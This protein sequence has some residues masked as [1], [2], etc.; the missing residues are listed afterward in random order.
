MRCL[1]VE[2]EPILAEMLIDTL[3]D[4][5]F[6][7]THLDRGDGVVD[8]VKSEDPTVVL[9]DLMLPGTDGFSICRAIRTF[10]RVPLIMITA[11]VEEGDRL[12]GFD[13]G[14][15]DY[16][17]KPFHAAEVAARVRALL[18]RS[19]EWREASPGSS[20][21]LDDARLEARWRGATL[22][23]TPLEFRLLSTLG[24][25]PGRVYSR[26]E[27]LDTVYSD[28]RDVSDR[29][30]DSHIKNLR[31]KISEVDDGDTPIESI[32]GVGYKFKG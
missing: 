2:D 5:G 3:S 29:T 19:I 26:N 16:I 8:W 11:K 13:L 21:E 30:I 1:I 22:D 14:A 23:L 32:Y 7:T 20:L 28:G 31:R 25:R 12:R 10:S 4:A 6:E 15:D 24:K 17:C 9:L 27:L 18:R